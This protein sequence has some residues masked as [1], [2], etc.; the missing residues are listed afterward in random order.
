MNFLTDGQK[1]ETDGQ[2]DETI[3]QMIHRDD[4]DIKCS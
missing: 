2:T 3:G 1:D 4:I